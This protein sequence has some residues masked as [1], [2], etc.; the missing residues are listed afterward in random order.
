MEAFGDGGARVVVIDGG[1]LIVGGSG[2]HMGD[3][4]P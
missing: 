1:V 3:Y 2:E 4:V